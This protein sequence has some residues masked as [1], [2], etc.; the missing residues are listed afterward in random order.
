MKPFLEVFNLIDFWEK[1]YFQKMYAV[2]E[3][4]PLLS[5]GFSHSSSHTHT[6]KI[7]RRNSYFPSPGYVAGGISL[8]HIS[9]GSLVL[10]SA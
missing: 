9:M 2:S 5:H 4:Y 10:F 7:N 8:L 3:S 6:K 1:R